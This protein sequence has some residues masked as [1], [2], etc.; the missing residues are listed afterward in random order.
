[1]SFAMWAPDFVCAFV[2]PWLLSKDI[3]QMPH[4]E[5][6]GSILELVEENIFY[7]EW[8]VFITGDELRSFVYRRDRSE[9]I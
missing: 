9:L 7:D 2:A 1:M 8:L 5:P 3:S 6:G 4:R